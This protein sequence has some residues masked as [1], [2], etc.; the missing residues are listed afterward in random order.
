MICPY[1]PTYFACLLLSK[2]QQ[3]LG[4]I[5]FSSTEGITIYFSEEQLEYIEFLDML[6]RRSQSMPIKTGVSER[7][8]QLVAA[9]CDIGLYPCTHQRTLV[10]EGFAT[11]PEL[12]DYFGIDVDEDSNNEYIN[13]FLSYLGLDEVEEDEVIDEYE[14]WTDE[15]IADQK[16]EDAAEEAAMDAEIEAEMAE[17]LGEQGYW[18]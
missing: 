14:G 9:I 10:P 16:R 7:D 8:L 15:M 6:Y 13:D 18:Y 3:M 4:G 11:F 5:P 17:A 2:M 12:C 1:L